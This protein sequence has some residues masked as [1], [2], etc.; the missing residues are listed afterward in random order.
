MRLMRLQTMENI[1]KI[2]KGVNI[3][4]IKVQFIQQKVY[5]I[6]QSTNKTKVESAIRKNILI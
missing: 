5:R 6:M 2:D 3:T 4:K 1:E